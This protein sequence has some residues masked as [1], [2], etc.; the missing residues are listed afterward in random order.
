MRYKFGTGFRLALVFFL[1]LFFSSSSFA[2]SSKV[3]R[4]SSSSDLLKG[5]IEKVVIGSR[6]TIQLGRLSRSLV[7]FGAEGS[8]ENSERSTASAALIKADKHVWSINSI[9]LS[10]GT[11]YFGTSPNGGIYKYSLGK[12]TKIYPQQEIGL[13]AETAGKGIKN[14]NSA[15]S[16]SS[17]VV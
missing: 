12:L 14:T 5:R 8:S 7:S 10:G 4:H 2:V 13:T 16:A 1:C 15:V 6:G 17:A 9:V 3:T 11:V